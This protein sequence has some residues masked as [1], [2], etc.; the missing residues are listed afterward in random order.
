MLSI[1]F[2]R[3][4]LKDPLPPNQL[5]QIAKRYLSSILEDYKAVKGQPVRLGCVHLQ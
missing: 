5:F 3:C 2:Q 4:Q 1:D